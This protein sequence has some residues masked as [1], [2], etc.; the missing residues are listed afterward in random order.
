[1]HFSAVYTCIIYEQLLISLHSIS[2]GDV[3]SIVSTN[4]P[5]NYNVFQNDLNLL[6]NTYPFLQIQTI[7]YSVLGQRI[8]SIKIGNGAN[9]VLYTAAFHANEWITAP[10]LMKFIEDFSESYKNSSTILNYDSKTIFNSTTIHLIPMVNP[11]G[12][13]LVTNNLNNNNSYLSAKNI[14]VKYPNIPFPNGWKANIRG[15]DLKIYQSIFL[16]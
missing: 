4:I 6:N 12:V 8:Y 5:Y 7:G 14:S 13:N 11:D 2:L 9:N 15:V 10:I 3:M 16:R 1:M